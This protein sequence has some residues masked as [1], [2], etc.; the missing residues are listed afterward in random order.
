MQKYNATN[1]TIAMVLQTLL[2]GPGYAITSWATQ[3][4]NPFL[5]YFIRAI[6]AALFFALLFSLWK[7]WGIINKTKKEWRKIIGVAISGTV[8]NQLF[9]VVAIRYATPASVAIIFS[10]TPLVVLLISVFR[11]IEK[12]NSPKMLGIACALA[13]VLIVLSLHTAGGQAENPLWG[14]AAGLFA[15]F[16]W[17]LYIVNSRSLAANY[18]AVEATG[19]VMLLAPLIF[20]PIG[21]FLFQGWDYSVVS[22]KAW[23]GLGY[24]IAVN[25]IASYFLI[26]Y[27]LKRLHPSQ[28]AIF[29]NAQPIVATFFSVITGT[30]KLS[31]SFVVGSLLTLGGIYIIN[32]S[33]H[34]AVLLAK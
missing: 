25:S 20:A 16:F 31:V 34:K 32:R 19:L 11:K 9:F 7:K 6:G 26:L 21:V 23:F 3:E 28:V 10:L 5:L 4:I 17:S 18:G 22:G 2:V 24:L 1:A 8:L 12:L 27:A 13:G 15:L 14:A 30:E 29:I 33:Q